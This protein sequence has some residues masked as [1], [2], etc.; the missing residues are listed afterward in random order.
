ME[1]QALVDQLL[2]FDVVEYV[3]S[4]LFFCWKP[5]VSFKSSLDRVAMIGWGK[6]IYIDIYTHTL[7]ASAQLYRLLK[8]PRASRPYINPRVVNRLLFA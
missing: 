4:C 7:T 5:F 6:I 3:P 2:Q 1:F 8:S